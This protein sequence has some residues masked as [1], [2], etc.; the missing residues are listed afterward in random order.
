M[1]GKHHVDT[2][3]RAMALETFLLATELIEHRPESLPR[4]PEKIKRFSDLIKNG[5]CFETGGGSVMSFTGRPLH[6]LGRKT[7][8]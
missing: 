4:D 7:S 5:H 2:E 8:I 3:I 1:I 6:T